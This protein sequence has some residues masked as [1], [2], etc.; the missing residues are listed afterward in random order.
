M[1]EILNESKQSELTKSTICREATAVFPAQPR[2]ATVAV[3]VAV[4]VD[5]ST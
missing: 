1:P 3:A 4:A 2:A 5:V